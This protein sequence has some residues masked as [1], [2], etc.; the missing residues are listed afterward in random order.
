VIECACGRGY[1][2]LTPGKGLRQSR[3]VDELAR[4]AVGQRVKDN[5]R[6]GAVKQ[7]RAS[8]M[9]RGDDWAGW[10]FFLHTLTVG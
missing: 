5:G 2:C 3:C 4:G 8:M 1:D 9:V 7:V 10:A 6:G